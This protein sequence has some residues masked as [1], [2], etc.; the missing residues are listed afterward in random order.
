MSTIQAVPPRQDKEAFPTNIVQEASISQQTEGMLLK[1]LIITPICYQVRIES[2]IF[3]GIICS[4]L[5]CIKSYKKKSTL[6][7]SYLSIVA[8]SQRV[9]AAESHASR[10]PHQQRATLTDG[11]I[12]RE[13]H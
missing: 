3:E 12:S 5:F 13:S 7:E 6:I 2:L 8:Q 4:C 10:Q 9:T 1:P 11:H